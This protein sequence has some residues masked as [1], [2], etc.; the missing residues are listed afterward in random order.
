MIVL[1]D[2]GQTTDASAARLTPD[3]FARWANLTDTG[4]RSV[5]LSLPKF[6]REGGTIDFTAALQQLGLRSAFDRPPGIAH[7]DGIAPRRPTTTARSPKSAPRPSSPSTKPAPRLPP[8]PPWSSWEPPVSSFPPSRPPSSASTARSSSPS[9][10]APAALASFAA[11]SPTCR[12]FRPEIELEPPLR[13]YV[14]LQSAMSRFATRFCT[15]TRR[16]L[17]PRTSWRGC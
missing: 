7:F 2:A 6:K 17:P 9:N 16:V 1:P 10:T 11:A 5:T 12:S 8:R 3:P 15:T 14:V 4:R 13:V